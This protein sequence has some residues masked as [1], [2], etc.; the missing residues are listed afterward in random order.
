MV[1][2]VFVEKILNDLFALL[3]LVKSGLVVKDV[4]LCV[5][6]VVIR[7]VETAIHN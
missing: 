5:R 6:I 2:C 7:F 4:C 1:L 3:A